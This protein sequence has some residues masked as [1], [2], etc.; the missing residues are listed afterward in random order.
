MDH[1]ECLGVGRAASPHQINVA[2]RFALWRNGTN[3]LECRRIMAAWFVVGDPNRRF[4]Y[5]FWLMCNPGPRDTFVPVERKT[6]T[7]QVP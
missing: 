6:A 1:Y 3:A 4:D 2:A 5:D 7:G